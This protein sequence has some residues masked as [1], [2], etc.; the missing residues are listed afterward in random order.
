MVVGVLQ[1]ELRID[2]ARSLKDKRSVVNSLKDRLH[3]EYQ[4]SVAEVD[5]QDNHQYATLGI[6]MVSNQGKQCQKVLNDI[7]NKLKSQRDCVLSDHKTE[8]FHSH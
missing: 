8:I 5:R 6:A 1:I 7:V 2:W 3:R 4:I